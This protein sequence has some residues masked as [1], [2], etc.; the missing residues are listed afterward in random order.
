LI[1]LLKSDSTFL[2]KVFIFWIII[3]PITVR[4]TLNYITFFTVGDIGLFI[5]LAILSV[6]YSITGCRIKIFYPFF[7]ML[8]FLIPFIIVNLMAEDDA[9]FRLLRT[10]FFTLVAAIFIPTFFNKEVAVSIFKK[11]AI[12]SSVYVILQIFIV[13]VFGIR[14]T[15]TIQFLNSRP[16]S[17]TN[18]PYAFFDEPAAASIFLSI[19]LVFML[20]ENKQRLNKYLPELLVTVAII[21]TQAT[22]GLGLLVLI[23]GYWIIFSK[24][25]KWMLILLSVPIIAFLEIIFGFI[26]GM[27]L[28]GVSVTDDGL[29]LGQGTLWRLEN[30]ALAF[31]ISNLTTMQVFFGRGMIR[32]AVGGTG[33]LPGWALCFVYFGIVGLL[34]FISIYLYLLFNTK[35][36][37]RLLVICFIV[38]NVFADYLFGIGPLLS[39]PFIFIVVNDKKAILTSLFKK[40]SQRIKKARGIKL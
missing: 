17:D 38:I 21:F 27:F 6:K 18:R 25:S 20:S 23:W 39:L 33:F 34:F 5:I 37:G 4:Y 31:D 2:E 32:E 11:T 35:G 26:E 30:I 14:L 28:R 22:T 3:F 12:I 10:I 29:G 36:Y 40:M 19:A 9:L 24:Q 1:S 8:L 7:L 15:G 16:L 13:R